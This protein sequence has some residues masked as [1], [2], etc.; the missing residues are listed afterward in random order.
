MGKRRP[1]SPAP[2]K[3]ASLPGA[4]GASPPAKSR[5]SLALPLAALSLFYAAPLLSPETSIQWD[6]ADVHYPCQ[7]YFAQEILAGRL[8]VWTPYVFSGFPFLAD[9][10]V[11]AFYPL[12]WP[13]MLAGASPR[14]IQAEM[15]FH[16]LLA[17][18]GAYLFFWLVAADAWAAALGAT[19]YALSGFFAAHA[20]HVGMFQAASLLPWLLYCAERALRGPFL[21]W[22]GA[23]GAVAGLMFL[24]G[25]L[26]TALYGSAA[27]ALYGLLRVIRTP[28]L[29]LS[30]GGLLAGVAAIAFLISAVMVLPGLELTEH[31]V[32][33]GLDF[34]AS[35]E[36]ALEVRALATLVFPN[37]L[38]ALGERYQGPGDRTQYYF[39]GGLL[40]LPLAVLGIYFRRGCL[41][42]AALILVTVW[43]MLGPA[44]GLYRLATQ[45][46]WLGK[47]RA[48]V[49]A[50]FVVAFGLA[51]MAASGL[52]GLRQRLSISWLGW[53]ACAVFALDLCWA[54]SWT[55]PLICARQSFAEL[56]GRG[57]ELLRSRVA[58]VVSPG[59]RFAA[60]D[61]LTIFG[62]MNSPLEVGIET[63]YGYNPLEL[64]SYSRYRQAAAAN[65]RLL[66]ALAASW[67]LDPATGE[68]RRR[69]SSLPKAWFPAAVRRVDRPDQQAA[70]LLDLDPAKEAVVAASAAPAQEAAVLGI[71]TGLREWRVRYRAGGAGLLLLSLPWYPGWTGEAAGERLPVL[72]VNLAL[73]GVQVPAG[74]HELRLR[75]QSRRLG[76]GALLSVAGWLA[77]VGLWILGRPPG[78]RAATAKPGG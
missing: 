43:F 51:W 49:H 31:S 68:V 58:P 46:P 37:A 2:S 35:H 48:P 5:L 77:A 41:V 73:S 22:L 33:A 3:A 71:E 55:N 12:N 6:A 23:S 59:T 63:T 74:E 53:S 9:P 64:R 75:F 65:P 24:T 19:A 44:A 13:F 45:I 69:P 56:Y 52:A 66:D 42:P 39:Y 32:R 15:A 29:M 62:P 34:S 28:G 72:P 25:H 54:N 36:G 70:A 67:A 21:P 20:S 17:M 4:R 76:P 38:G 57:T 18:A 8:P 61:K 50:W 1:K 40:L 26:Q 60:P 10:Q 14:L 16:A 7:R 30:C 78:A 47:V 27:L 11:G